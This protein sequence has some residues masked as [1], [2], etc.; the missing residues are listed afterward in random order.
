MLDLTRRNLFVGVAAGTAATLMPRVAMA[1][2]PTIKSTGIFSYKV[3][4][5]EIIQLRDG[6]RTFPMPDTFIVNV[7]KDK[8]IEAA[9]AAYIPD[10]QVTIPFS[11]IIVNTG[12]KLIAIDTGNGLG[13]FAGSKG[14]V[15]QTR[16]NM[17]AAGIDPKQ[18]DIVVISHFHG[19]HVGGLKNADGS[20]AYPNAEIKV[21]AVEAAFW[22]DD[23]N[24]S[25]ANGFNKA[26]FPNV[27]KMMDGLKVTPYEADK[28]VAPGITSMFTPGHTPGHMSFVV[29]SGSSRILVQ[30]D[31]TNIPSFFLR[32]P[33]W[34]VMFD[35]DPTIAIAT[36]HKV[37]DMAAAEK[38]PVTGY[39]FP[40]PCFGHVEKDGSGYRLVPAV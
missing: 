4:D 5:Y 17:E 9:A 34:Q 27:K 18:I 10:G 6:A 12:S 19:D 7:S 23:S 1:A 3:G 25:K 16:G 40:F 31:V 38:M 2:A 15:G 8:A 32:N 29:A 20:P 26:Q 11:P 30:S 33:D 36:R 24:Q 13:A 28:E 14:V 37:Y 21:P 22:A 35:N 39:H